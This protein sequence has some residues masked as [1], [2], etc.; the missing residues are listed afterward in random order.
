MKIFAFRKEGQGVLKI[1]KSDLW[2][3]FS[4]R[5]L[6]FFLTFSF[7]KAS[8]YANLNFGKPYTFL[9]LLDTFENFL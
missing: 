5:Q 7:F 8:A 2:L 4:V 3:P 1:V 6:A 9:V